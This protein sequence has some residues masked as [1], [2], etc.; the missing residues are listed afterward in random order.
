MKRLGFFI[1]IGLLSSGCLRLDSFL[2]NND[3]SITEYK[4]DAYE[5]EV[6][7]P[8]GEEYNMADSVT[9]VFTLSSDLDGDI[10]SIYAIYLGNIADIA[11]DTVILYLHGTRDH[12]EFYWP[13]VKLLG[14]VGH[15][16]R[17]GVLAIDYRGYGVSEGTPS[18]EGMYADADAALKW[19]KS[20]G[21][22]DDRLI[23][24]GFSLGSAPATELMA[25]A[26]SMQPS[27]LILESPF[28]SDEVM[29]QDA[30]KLTLP[31]SYFTNLEINN[32]DEIKKVE[33]PFFWIHGVDDDFL[34]MQTHGEVVYKNYDGSYSEAHRIDGG[35][36]GDVPFVMGY[37]EYLEALEAF[38]E[39]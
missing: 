1:I 26:R 20:N 23:I 33:E 28:G 17:Y 31:G 12:L 16:N 6:E 39:R 2:Y 4:L 9:H 13:R 29:V 10:A 11:T 21:L 24:Y 22:T 8:V 38:I 14:N 15:K 35:S 32:A 34:A 5:G 25:N 27:K 3:N 37:P 36:H 7:I 30:S 19:L 18:E